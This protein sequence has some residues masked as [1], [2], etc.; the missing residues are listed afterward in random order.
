MNIFSNTISGISITD[1]LIALGIAI[2]ATLILLFTKR[3]VAAR[4]V[5]LATRT[6]TDVDD[7]LVGLIDKISPLFILLAGLVIGSIW[8][9]LSSQAHSN[10][11]HVFFIALLIQAGFWGSSVLAYLIT[12]STRLREYEDPSS[13]TTLSVLGFLSRLALWSVVLLIILDNLGFDITTL[14][15]SLGIG[16]I[17]VALAAQNI[18]GELFASLS[19]ALDK[20]FIIGDF[21]VVDSYMGNIEKIGM[22]TTQIRSLSG[23]LIIFSNT[24]LLKS[25][26]RNYKRMQERRIVFTL[27]LVYGTPYEKLVRVP[28]LVREII[29]AETMARFD[30]AHF[31]GY[32]ASSLIF[33]FVYYVLSAEYVEFMDVQ[34]RINLAIYKS[35]ETEALD[36]AF[37][38]QTLHIQTPS[39]VEYGGGSDDEQSSAHNHLRTQETPPPSEE[40]T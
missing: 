39:S 18:L 15:A 1:W 16:G 24:D 31:K 6:S 8:L 40:N 21:I 7:M 32:G 30:R 28:E 25:R 11:D 12:K 17:A 4:L 34:Q 33:E 20:P 38:T 27:D 3:L 5:K 22:R 35:F 13:Q 29:E 19:I 37:P 23:E 9:P 36:F 14:L 2:G 26:V 10:V